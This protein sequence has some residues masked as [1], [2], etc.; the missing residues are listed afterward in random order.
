MA[1]NEVSADDIGGASEVLK[2]ELLIV[3]VQAIRDLEEILD[4]DSSTSRMA[5][6]GISSRNFLNYFLGKNFKEEI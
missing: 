5:G 1:K 3:C 4:S 2:Q 6:F